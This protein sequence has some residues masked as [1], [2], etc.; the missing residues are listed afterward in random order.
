M[1][2][3]PLL[4]SLILLAPT[5]GFADII[6]YSAAGAALVDL[7]VFRKTPKPEE[8][9]VAVADLK[10]N[11]LTK[12]IS[13]QPPAI[14]Q[15]LDPLK[16]SLIPD[17]FFV[18]TLLIADRNLNKGSKVLTL[19][20]Q[21][22][23][24][25]DKLVSR[26]SA[27]PPPGQAQVGKPMVSWIFA[28]R[29]MET[30][31]EYDPEV[32]SRI[33]TQQ[34]KESE[35]ALSPG[36]SSKTDSQQRTLSTSGGQRR[37]ADKAEFILDE[38]G[39]GELNAGMSERM[40]FHGYNPLSPVRLQVA[41]GGSFSMSKVLEDFKQSSDLS[42]DNKA[43]LLGV[44]QKAKLDYL[45][46]GCATLNMKSRHSA[47]GDWRVGVQVTA[48]VYKFLRDPAT[49][50]YIDLVTVGSAPPKVVPGLAKESREA[51]IAAL[52]AAAREAADIISTQLSKQRGQASQ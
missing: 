30:L 8:E 48:N 7:G 39:R 22:D 31:N 12:A 41:S 33:S 32:F 50:D 3:I 14:R 49:G 38:E 34:A 15:K 16:D 52:Q 35:V 29:R 18:G 6:R 25:T 47:S 24:D 37:R 26:A 21:V 40:I 4:A 19:V 36:A 17:E 44:A 45:A 10:R 11:I 5:A 42:D 13:E 27:N 43:L 28:A 1:N 46:T 20:G 2:K 51:E 23:V 9:A